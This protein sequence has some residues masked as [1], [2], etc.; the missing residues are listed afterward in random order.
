VIAPGTEHWRRLTVK[1]GWRRFVCDE[2]TPRPER[3]SRADHRRLTE[4][5]R[6]IYD[7]RRLRHAHGFGPIKSLYADTHRTLSRLVRLNELRG[8][9][10]RHGAALD[11]DPGNGKSTIASQFGRAHERRCRELYTEELTPEGHE[12]LP[13]LYV[14][15]DAYPTIKGLNEAMLGFYGPVPGRAPTRRLTQMV[16]DCARLCGTSLIIIDD[17]HLL[18]L[19][20]ESDRDANNHLKR[21]ANDLAATF[22]YAGVGLEH[23]GFMHEGRLG[24]DA[25]LAQI[26]R[27]FKRIGVGPLG[28]S[29]A[30][31]RELWLGILSV[32][33]AELVLLAARP[34]D[35]TGRADHLWQ[36]TQGV[37]GSLTQLLTEAT[38]E[39]IDTGAER[40]T[41]KLLDGIDIGY[42]AEVGAGRTR[43]AELRR[44]A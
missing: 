22:I 1:E 12:Y 14:N 28:R 35:L 38:A 16:L 21:L 3:L 9:G 29:R 2:P 37:I 4:E 23:S 15:L 32:F 30:A 5:E 27:R 42:A 19:R 41:Q 11:G 43:S 6:S 25:Q 26:S 8:P 17:I 31:D 24:T 36:R 10:A 39:A 34:G 13:V 20:R 18:E 40:I 44:A 33:E 7:E